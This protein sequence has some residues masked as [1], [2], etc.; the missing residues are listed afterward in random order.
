MNELVL[1]TALTLMFLY[2]DFVAVPETRYEFGDILLNL[3]YLNFAINLVI[4]LFE[5]L[6]GP[7]RKKRLQYRKDQALKQRRKLMIRKK[8]EK[9]C[10]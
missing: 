8:P 2:S 5:V 3:L 9:T 1:L 4:I 7:I 10:R 6:S